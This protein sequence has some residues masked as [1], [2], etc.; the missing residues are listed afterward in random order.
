MFLSEKNVSDWIDDSK[1]FSNFWRMVGVEFN[2]SGGDVI[3][4]TVTPRTSRA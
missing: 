3:L 1:T 2:V 4:V